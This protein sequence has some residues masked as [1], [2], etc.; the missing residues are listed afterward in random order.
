M[1]YHSCLKYRSKQ[2]LLRLMYSVCHMIFE[3]TTNTSNYEKT[4]FLICAYV[5]RGTHG[6]VLVGFLG[7]ALNDTGLKCCNDDH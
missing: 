5:C 4:A 3:L 7:T 2:L 6:I 1:N